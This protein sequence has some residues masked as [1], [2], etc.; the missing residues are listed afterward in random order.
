MEEPLLP[1]GSS[2]AQTSK[3][4]QECGRRRSGREKGASEEKND[5]G[6]SRKGGD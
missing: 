1:S 6:E 2:I 3:S 4:V 5:G